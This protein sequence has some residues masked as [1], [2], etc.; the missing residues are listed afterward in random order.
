MHKA[1]LCPPKPR[2]PWP[3]T[4]GCDCIGGEPF[5]EVARERL[6][7][8]WGEMRTQGR[9][10]HPEKPPSTRHRGAQRTC[11]EPHLQPPLQDLREHLAASLEPGRPWRGTCARC[12]APQAEIPRA[13][14]LSASPTHNVWGTSGCRRKSAVFPVFLGKQTQTGLCLSTPSWPGAWRTDGARAQIKDRTFSWEEVSRGCPGDQVLVNIFISDLEGAV[15]STL[16]K[17]PDDADFGGATG[18]SMRTEIW[19]RWGPRRPA[20]RVSKKKLRTSRYPGTLSTLCPTT[21]RTMQVALVSALTGQA[22]V[23]TVRNGQMQRCSGSPLALG[24][25]LLL[26]KTQSH[27]SWQHVHLAC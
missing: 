1:E 19:C 25:L 15:N 26:F 27:Q 18:K 23:S 14:S 16:I 4:S 9:R 22:F 13:G 21:G 24:I 17:F 5:K 11:A 20:G 6:C 12:T 3:H 10:E 2:G 7:V 8:L